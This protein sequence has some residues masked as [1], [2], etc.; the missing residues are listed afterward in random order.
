MHGVS[1]ALLVVLALSGPRRAPDLQV[2]A[3]TADGAIL[4]EL[5]DATARALLASGARVVL[6]GPTSGACP[7]CAK[8]M[9]TE[10]RPGICRVEVR[11]ERHAASVTLHLPAGSPL[12]ERARAIAIQ[13][14]LLVTWDTRSPTPPRPQPEVARTEPAFPASPGPEPAPSPPSADVPPPTPGLPSETLRTPAT[15]PPLPGGP[16]IDRPVARAPAGAAKPDAH[17]ELPPAAP[18]RAASRPPS[19]TDV[20]SVRNVSLKRQWPWIPTALGA[21][22]A[23]AAGICAVVAHNRYGA[24]ANKNQTLAHAQAVKSGGENWQAASIVLSGVAVVGLGSGLV[25]FATRSPV[26]ALASPVS[27]GGVIAI[28]GDFP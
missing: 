12:F 16:L 21:G 15:E 20:V 26:T 8:V 2:E 7:Y 22:A 13:A 23:V 5:A 25:G 10:F 18:A 19:P 1:A 9:V 11:Q 4:S 17:A 24:L 3:T 6:R 28:A 27:G 14:R